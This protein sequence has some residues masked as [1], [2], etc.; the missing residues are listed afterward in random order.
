MKRILAGA[1][2]LALTACGEGS[3]DFAVDVQMSASQVQL[4]LLGLQGGTIAQ[5]AGAPALRPN[6]PE[7]GI[8][9]Y[10]FV[11]AEGDE[12]GK[13]RF[14]IEE[15]GAVSS[16]IHAA[17]DLDPVE[18]DDD[19]TKM[20]VDERKA[21][22]HLETA[23]ESWAANVQGDGYG[24]PVD[25]GESLGI[26]AVLLNS[27]L[28]G[29]LNNAAELFDWTG[30]GP[31]YGMADAYVGEGSDSYAVDDGFGEPMDK[32]P[33]TFGGAEDSGGWGEGG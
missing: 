3:E 21:E 10:S 17:V 5:V 24:S 2:L 25:V 7:A 22:N 14:R 9:E 16:R 13:V 30:E 6:N 4:E 29:S 12:V 26:I 27:D 8:V 31:G 20:V 33:D 15:V 1:A 19:G 23:L 28:S 32:G 18:F 11:G